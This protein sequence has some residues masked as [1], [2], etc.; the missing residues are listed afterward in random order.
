MS[1][2]LAASIAGNFESA[3]RLLE[4]ALADCPDGLW[5]TDLW[6]GDGTTRRLPGGG[7]HSSAPWFLGYHALTCLGY[8]LGGDFDRWVPPAPFDDNT[9][10]LP[11]RVF[12][13]AETLEYVAWCRERAR[14]PARRSL[15]SGRAGRCLPRIGTP[16]S[17]TQT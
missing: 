8:D 4:A 14:R 3:L 12:D 6:P 13:K 9:F 16:E 7:L 2:L 15:T 1:A 5:E 10:G 11:N 17:D